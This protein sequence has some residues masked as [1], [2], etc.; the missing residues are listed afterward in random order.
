MRAL[1]LGGGILATA[2]PA[3][4]ERRG[5]VTTVHPRRATDI[6]DVAAVRKAF[7]ATRPELV[8]NAAAYTKVDD[9]EVERAEAFLTNGVAPGLLARECR[10]RGALFLHVSSDFVFAGDKGAPY[11]EE[12][13]PR[14]LSVY[15][16]SK[17]LGE[18]EA[19][20][21]G[22]DVLIVRTSWLYGGGGNNFVAAIHAKAAR[23]ETPRV[24]TDQRGRPTWAGHLADA[25]T[26]LLAHDCRGMYHYAD[27]VVGDAISWYDLASAVVARS[28]TGV[29]VSPI[30]SAE[31]PRPAR[32][33]PSSALD[34]GRY[35]RTVGAP[36]H[37]WEEGVAAYLSELGVA[38]APTST[39]TRPEG[40]SPCAS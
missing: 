25:L 2:L 1:V 5:H 9:C 26:L 16:Q 4:L 7:D 33:P 32:R 35:E 18:M 39:P 30:T 11:V 12:D 23:G 22:G 34:T 36:P 29:G 6:R 15:G 8:V 31:L 3:W 38:T 27:A 24:V 10:E 21:E 40:D 14:P 17:L 19:L 13:A 20:R 28:G 37:P